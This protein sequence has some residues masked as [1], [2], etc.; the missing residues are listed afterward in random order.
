MKVL[1]RVLRYASCYRLYLFLSALLAILYV[2][3]T[4]ICPIIV[5]YAIDEIVEGAINTSLILKYI[6][7]LIFIIIF[8]ALFGYVMNILISKVTYLTVKDL[9]NDAFN[10][11]LNVP[12]ATLDNHAHGDII[13]R[14][15]TDI[16]VVQDGLLQSFTEALTGIITIV[17]TLVFM[18]I[19]NYQIGLIVFALTPLSLIVAMVIA[20]LSFKTIKNTSK[21]KGDLTSFTNEMFE[22]QKIV[23]AYNQMDENQAKFEL[24]DDELYRHGVNA[25]FYASLSNPSTRFVNAIIYMVVAT[26]GSLSIING[27]QIL[28]IGLLSVF[29]SYANQYTKPFNSISA[30]WAELQN[31][32]ASLRRIFDWLDEK[33]V[34]TQTNESILLYG[35][36]DFENVCFSYNEKKVI[37][38]NFN[39]HVKKGEK[40]AIVG[41]TGC[42]KTTLINLIMKFYDINEGNIFLDGKNINELS[43][44]TIRDNVGMVL[45]DTWLFN[46]T[47]FENIAYGKDDATEEEIIK[48]AKDAFCHDFI[49]RLPNGYQ[50]KV[51][52]DEG[53]SEGQK[54]LLCIA[55]L[56]LRLPSI[57]ILDEATSNIDTRTELKISK[58]FNHLMEGRTA[59]IIAHRLQ[60]IK[61]ADKIVVLKDGKILEVGTHFELIEKDGFY[62][63]IYNSQFQT[64]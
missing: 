43:L 26:F 60:T 25:Q 21:V 7:I 6:I 5:G 50:T 51:S 15:I 62:K 13:S 48:A 2:S 47:I 41:P 16:D 63:E 37:I 58:A 24:I 12:I 40:V 10:K 18:L 8:G 46:G 36:V 56:M 23:L 32:I 45:Q 34:Y 33:E 55:R 31:S 42:G 64:N 38:D 3:A 20:K 27:S 49:M 17:F 9:R 11:L 35:D 53:V 1:K 4:L 61:T 57:L 39:L 28:T 52:I 59:F 22:N 54:Q 29:L 30:V 44:A 19:L 14:I